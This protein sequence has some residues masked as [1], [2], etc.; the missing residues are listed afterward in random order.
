[1]NHKYRYLNQK[2]QNHTNVKYPTPPVL[3]IHISSTMT[4]NNL[5]C[6]QLQPLHFI[7]KQTTIKK[8]AGNPS[9]TSMEDRPRLQRVSTECLPHAMKAP[10]SRTLSPGTHGMKGLTYGNN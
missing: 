4:L 6:S 2:D 10:F 5:Q 7:V 9:L 3:H 1:M 8:E